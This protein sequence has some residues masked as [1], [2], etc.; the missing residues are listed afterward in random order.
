MLYDIF[1]GIEL[2]SETTCVP[3]VPSVI[4]DTLRAYEL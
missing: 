2:V 4:S 3:E 1:G